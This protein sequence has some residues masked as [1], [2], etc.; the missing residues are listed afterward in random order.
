VPAGTYTLAVRSSN[1]LGTSSPSNAV[2]LTFP[3]ACTGAPEAPANFDVTKNGSTISA[4]WSLPPSGPAP[5]S[6]LVIVSGGF[7]GELAVTERK[8]SGAVGAG[9]YTISVVASNACG[10]SAP[11]PPVL[12]AIP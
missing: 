2:T 12:V 8:I 11:T 1:A 10:S 6:Y 3:G 5:T 7:N 9:S 4:Q